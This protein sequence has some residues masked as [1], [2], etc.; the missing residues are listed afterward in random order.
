LEKIVNMNE[1]K[2][3]GLGKIGSG[4]TPKQSIELQ[5]RIKNNLK[6]VGIEI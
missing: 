1:W 4:S 6:K 5:E 3:Y 2:E